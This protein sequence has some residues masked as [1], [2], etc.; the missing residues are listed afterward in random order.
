MKD[1]GIGSIKAMVAL[2]KLQPCNTT[3]VNHYLGHDSKFGNKHL[4]DLMRAGLV[5]RFKWEQP[6]VEITESMRSGFEPM[7][8]VKRGKPPYLYEL[9]AAGQRAAEHF[10]Q[11]LDVLQT[12]PPTPTTPSMEEIR[13]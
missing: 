4:Q 7:P 5:R 3:C 12:T 1:L 11:G 9:T 2:S 6:K 13:K 8:F 10:S